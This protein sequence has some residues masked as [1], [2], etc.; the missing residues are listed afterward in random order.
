MLGRA[1]HRV[2]AIYIFQSYTLTAKVQ[3]QGE[4]PLC[5]LPET[6]EKESLLKGKLHMRA[7]DTHTHTHTH[8]F[9]VSVSA[10]VSETRPKSCPRKEFNRISLDCS[11]F[12]LYRTHH[13][14]PLKPEKFTSLNR[15]QNSSRQLRHLNPL[16]QIASRNFF[17]P[18]SYSP[19]ATGMS[20]NVAEKAPR[21][22]TCTNGMAD[23]CKKYSIRRQKEISRT[24]LIARRTF[25]L[26]RLEDR[27]FRRYIIS[28][29]YASAQI[30]TRV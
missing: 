24:I 7:R 13:I 4:S 1:K 30:K 28:F 5:L 29:S 16:S 17:F 15:R 10:Q 20:L 8:T 19:I 14:F 21:E 12:L 6:D 9:Q 23:L 25:Y 2:G 11:F 27:W 3:A 26:A 22:I 18:A